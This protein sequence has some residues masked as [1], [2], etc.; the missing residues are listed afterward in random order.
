M[1]A[2][3]SLN[4]VNKYNIYTKVE[5]DNLYETTMNVIYFFKL[6]VIQYRL[7]DVKRLLAEENIN[8]EDTLLL[9]SEQV[10]Y[11]KIKQELTNK[12]G[13]TILR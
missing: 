5:S 2:D 3:L 11:E 6:S 10:A 13:R 9:L 1:N 8:H 7:N 12:L 4:W